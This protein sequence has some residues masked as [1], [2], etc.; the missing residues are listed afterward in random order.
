[1]ETNLKTINDLVQLSFFTNIG[2]DISSAS[3][4][5]ELI[6]AIMA[7]IGTIF[8]PA[9]WSLLLRKH[10]SGE[11]TFIKV[12]GSGSDALTGKILKK[13][14]GI[15]GWIAENGQAAISDNVKTDPRFSSSM[16][17]ESGFNTRSI[18]GVP[19]KTSTRVFGVIELVNPTRTENFSAFDLKLLGTIADYAAIAMEK[20]YYIKALKRSALKD[21]LTGLNNRR[22]L[23]PFIRRELARAQRE[24]SPF[25][26]L[27][28]DIDDFKAINDTCGHDQ[29]DYVLKKVA[30]ILED[31]IRKIDF[32][33]RWGGDEFVLVLPG[34]TR[35]GAELIR[36]RIMESPAL[37][38][39][40]DNYQTG[41]SIG[42]HEAKEQE[43]EAILASVDK[44][45]YD[46]KITRLEQKPE[47]MPDALEQTLE[48]FQ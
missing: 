35:E 45:M 2:K 34:Q 23:M 25:T 16:D 44:D 38:E 28:V 29:G 39:L 12:I 26:L 42:I 13:G 5:K 24:N 40:T 41:L 21:P 32:L 31:S 43:A 20:L 46:E 4:L 47:D 6:D 1:M 22:P 3:T 9:H 48:E 10:P 15:A 8:A 33:C 36:K 11:L 19:L 30:K 37:K 17:E 7:H 18:I 14:Q 27:F